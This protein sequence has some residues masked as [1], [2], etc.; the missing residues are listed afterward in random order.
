MESVGGRIAA[1]AEAPLGMAE[2][3]REQTPCT[4]RVVILGWEV[5]DAAREIACG[6]GYDVTVISDPVLAD[7]THEAYRRILGPRD[8]GS[9]AV[10]RSCGGI[11]PLVRNGCRSVAV[12]IGAGCITGVDRVDCTGRCHLFV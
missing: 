1:G 8:P 11:T 9:V 7:Y 5:N 4:V 6:S 12:D 3:I 2:R 10:I